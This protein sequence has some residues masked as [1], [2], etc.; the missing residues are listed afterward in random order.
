MKKIVVFQSKYG[1]S[2][3]YGQWI[4]EALKCPVREAG[5]LSLTDLLEYDTIIF[6]GGIYAS[7]VSGFGLMGK[8]LEML[9]DKKIALCMVGM[10]GPDQPEVYQQIYLNHVPEQY[11]SMVTPFVLQGDLLFSRLNFLHR[12]M[13]NIPKKLAAKKPENE[14][15]P[16]DRFFIDNKGQDAHFISRENISKVVE[17]AEAIKD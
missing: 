6:A 15:T 4:G 5:K 10:T 17:Y 13:L 3:Q 8:N 12:L 16:L 14:R 1:S 7:Q 9:R 2:R 11:R